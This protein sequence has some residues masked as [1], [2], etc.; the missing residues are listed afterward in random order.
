[1]SSDSAAANPFAET[2]P[3]LDWVW[4]WSR[5]YVEAL[6]NHRAGTDVTAPEMTALFDEPLP[7]DGCSPENA[8]RAWLDRA[9]RGITGSSGPRNFGFVIGGTTPASLAAD[10]LASA[11]DQNSGLWVAG[12]CT[13]HTDEAVL[14]W[15][16]ELFLLPSSWAGT[17]TSGATMSNLVG[18]AAGRQWASWQLGF[19]AAADGLGG[20]PPIPVLSSTEIHASAVKSLSTLG[21]GRNAIRKLPAIDG[22]LDLAALQDAL[23]SIDGPVI[24]VANAG[25]VNTGAFDDLHGI[26]D[27]V[28]DH[29][30]GGWIHVDGA[31][32]LY[33]N[34]SPRTAHL[35]AG[36]ERVDSAGCDAHKWLNV[37]YDSGFAFVRDESLLLET[38]STR[39]AYLE[40][41]GEI[42]KD[43]DG[44][45]PVFSTRFRGLPMWCA[46]KAYG[47]AGYR[48]M[49]ERC[50]DNAA[51][52]GSWLDQT[53]GVE[54]LAPVRLNMVCWR[55]TPDGLDDAATDQFNR[56][57]V[58]AIQRDGRVFL[59]PTRWQ[60]KQAIRCAFDNWAT[61][62]AD[63]EVLQQ[64]VRQQGRLGAL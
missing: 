46:L 3:A 44:Y 57:A 22:V 59:T 52:F 56:D 51:A 20:H 31:F 24:V 58:A 13:S 6:P 62:A 61:S 2:L 10:W 8:V 18:L 49:V 16:K 38:F 28:A 37:P 29:P 34:L 32:G 21:F 45:G 42:G 5:R 41:I 25:E 50:L 40:P 9:E 17:L 35:L 55:F 33:A 26:A 63:V 1:M 39:G 23:S 43:L 60:G 64:V 15:L 47:R 7:E 54:L 53:H 14:R 4:E 27:L 30:G 48:A 19:D 36:I 12:P 11:I